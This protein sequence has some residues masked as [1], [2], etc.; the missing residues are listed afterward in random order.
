[1]VFNNQMLLKIFDTQ[2]GAQGMEGIGE[3]RNCLAPL[4]TQCGPS[5]VLVFIAANMVV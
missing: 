4:L 3:I 2:L 1:M 5:H